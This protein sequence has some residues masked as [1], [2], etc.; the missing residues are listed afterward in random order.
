MLSGYALGTFPEGSEFD[1]KTMETAS[2]LDT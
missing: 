2:D 1:P